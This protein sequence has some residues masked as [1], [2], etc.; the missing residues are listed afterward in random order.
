M[1]NLQSAHFWTWFRKHSNLLLVLSHMSTFER[2]YWLREVD[3]HL[4]AYARKLSFAIWYGHEHSGSLI[5]TAWGKAKHFRMAENLASKAPHMPGWKIIALQPPVIISVAG[6][7]AMQGRT[8]REAG[9]LLTN[10]E[11]W[12]AWMENYELSDWVVNEKG[13]LEQRKPTE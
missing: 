4:T 9:S 13:E 12:Q 5:I 2:E 3:A 10:I 1:N 11:E 7:P 8:H 6:A